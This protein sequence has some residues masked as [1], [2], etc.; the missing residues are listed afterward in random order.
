MMPC[1]VIPRKSDRYNSYSCRDDSFDDFPS[2][3]G[4]LNG[5]DGSPWCLKILGGLNGGDGCPSVCGTSASGNLPNH[6][7]NKYERYPVSC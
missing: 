3:L 7:I 1:K 4:G 5:G 6:I 2:I